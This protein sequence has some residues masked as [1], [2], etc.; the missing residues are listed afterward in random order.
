MIFK[1]SERFP[2]LKNM[3]VGTPNPSY[4]QNLQ[5][6]QINQYNVAVKI[7]QNAIIIT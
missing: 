2:I 6:N 3:A 7:I 5:D 4:I 1:T